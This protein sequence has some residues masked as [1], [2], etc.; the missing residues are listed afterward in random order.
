MRLFD[1]LKKLSKQNEFDTTPSCHININITEEFM[2]IN[3]TKLLLPCHKDEL[4]SIFGEWMFSMDNLTGTSIRYIYI[5]HEL[6]IVAYSEDDENVNCVSLQFHP[7]QK[8][9]AI[10]SPKNMFGGSITVNGES[11][12]LLFENVKSPKV[13]KIKLPIKLAHYGNFTLCATN[14]IR[15]RQCVQCLGINKKTILN[16]EG[17]E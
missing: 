6:G 13:D 10:N 7:P 11:W 5:W 8:K 2:D 17:T 12:E 3:G 14:N 16:Y 15:H 1:I 4:K 9:N